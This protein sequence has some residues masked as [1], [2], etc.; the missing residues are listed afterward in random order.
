M[1]LRFPLRGG[2]N[3]GEDFQQCRFPR[4]VPAH[5]S[6]D[7]AFFNLEAHILERPKVKGRGHAV[8]GFLKHRGMRIR[9]TKLARDPTLD[10]VH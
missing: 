2:G 3:A 8:R 6:N 9:P 4:T 10:L 7:I 1:E 5:D